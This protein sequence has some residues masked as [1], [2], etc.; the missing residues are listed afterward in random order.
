MPA[1]SSLTLLD[2][3]IWHALST[4]HSSFAEGDDLAKRY[5]PAVTPLAGTRD[6]ST[7][8]YTSL[9]HLLPPGG[10]AGI[11][12]EEPSSLPNDWRVVHQGRLNQMVWDRAVDVEEHPWE[13]MRGSNSDEMLALVEL[14]KPGPYGRRTPEMGRY[15]GIR[16]NG[17]LAAMAGERLRLPGYTEISAVCT[18]SNHRGRGYATS[19]VSV[20]VREVRERNEIPFLHV[21]IENLGAIRVYE[22]LGFKTRRVIHLAVVKREQDSSGNTAGHSH[23]TQS[24]LNQSH[25]TQ[26][27]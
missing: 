16:Q 25:L 6:Q 7:A 15:L 21:A 26:S 8:A 9:F 24:H 19:L 18:H 22:A 2:N 27:S 17:E 1:A 10:V 3:P 5:P 13:D 4:T 20:L 11:L 23:L 14:T 12:L